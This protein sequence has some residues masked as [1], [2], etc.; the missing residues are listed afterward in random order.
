MGMWIQFWDMDEDGR[1]MLCT[2]N[3]SSFSAM[4]KGKLIEAH[5]EMKRERMNREKERI[6][7]EFDSYEDVTN[8]QLLI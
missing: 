4:S 3:V 5:L 6:E 7:P 2:V 8:Q 1:D